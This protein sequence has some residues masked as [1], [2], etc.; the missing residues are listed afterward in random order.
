MRSIGIVTLIWAFV[1][2]SL[3]FSEGNAFIGGLDFAFLRGVGAEPNADYSATI[4][5]Q[6]FMIF[7]LMFAIITPALI[8]GAFAE[9]IKFSAKIAF[10]ILWTLVVYF[11]LAHIVWGKGGFLNAAL[12][13]SFPALDFGGYQHD[14]LWAAL[15]V[16]SSAVVAVVLWC[17]ASSSKKKIG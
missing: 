12:G 10:T 7:Q 15:V 17:L 16:F 14:E 3:V 2:Y 9:R 1:G 8:T 13:G 4:P 6:T 5:Q 11:P